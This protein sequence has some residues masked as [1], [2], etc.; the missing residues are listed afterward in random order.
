MQDANLTIRI[1]SDLKA[2]L[3]SRARLEE[4]SITEIVVR[5]LSQ[6]AA[7]WATKEQAK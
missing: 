4:R 5:A 7:R 3:Q 2:K 6:A 1:A